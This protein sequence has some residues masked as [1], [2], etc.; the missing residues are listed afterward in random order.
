M[1]RTDKINIL[2][3]DDQPA[4]LISY[5]VMLAELGEN[6]IKANNATEAL[7]Q[8]L[9]QDVAVVLVDVCM[10]DLDGF[11]L[12]A[13]IRE[14]PRFEKTAII[15]ISAIHLADD[16]RLRGYK[17]GAVDYLPV[18][19]VA[20]ILR[21]KV[22]VFADLYRKT[23]ELETLNA[24]LER[25]VGERTAEL[26]ASNARLVESEHRR[27]MALA[28][29]RM[30]SWDWD[31]ESG[32]FLWDEAHCRIVGVDPENFVISPESVRPLVH[33]GDWEKLKSHLQEARDGRPS[34]QL[35]ARFLR[36]DGES[37]WCTITAAASFGDT[38]KLQ[39]M[40][41]VTTD[42][43]DRKRAEEYH[44]MLAREVDHRAKNALAI[45]QS[46]VRLTQA[47]TTETYVRA[48]EGRIAALSHAHT[49]L[50]ETR[51]QGASLTTL[52][53]EEL[54]PYQGEGP[55]KIR[56]EGAEVTLRPVVAQSVALIVHELATN[57]AKYGALSSPEGKL[58]VFWDAR[59]GSG[60][61]FDWIETGG[62]E[63]IAPKKKGFGLKVIGATVE[64]QLR[65]QVAF[66]WRTDGLS[67]RFDIPPGN[68][69]EPPM[70][71]APSGPAPE[72]VRIRPAVLVVE[73]EALVAMM[74]Q[75]V[76]DEMGFDTVGPCGTV[77]DAVDAIRGMPVD[78]AVL[79]INLHG[80]TVYPVADLLTERGI[81]FAFITGYGRESIAARFAGA[82]VLHKPIDEET[83]RGA[84]LRLSPPRLEPV[85]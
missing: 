41:G 73:D 72:R 78:A 14:H 49:L 46:V 66:D 79:D 18:P 65:G 69:E 25:R 9:K 55:D 60:L 82:P 52:V 37:R 10:P 59:D 30:G 4:K 68:A 61:V 62:P 22:R 36:P 6:L 2:L 77:K 20:D 29:G 1:E 38:G 26:E 24:E 56:I 85:G 80:E 43:T 74:M 42:I 64:S 34:F 5:E 19:V 33:P 12:A 67:C 13:M 47:P 15:F 84:L 48:I 27:S 23:R 35:E 57:S 44:A 21:A 63:V 45:V 58:Y 75:D 76:L 3:V 54:A 83:L 40:S 50:S 16:D 39:R 71:Q 17:M 70:A 53:M 7:S 51:W 81:P 31:L 11:Q 28:A 32:V 8:L